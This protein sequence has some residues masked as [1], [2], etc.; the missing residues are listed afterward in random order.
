M[1]VSELLKRYRKEND[2]SLSEFAKRADLSKGYVSMLERGVNPR[3]NKP[4]SPTLV[5]LDKI[6]KA[7]N[8]NFDDLLTLLDSDELL[9]IDENDTINELSTFLS[10]IRIVKN[11]EDDNDAL[12]L[13]AYHRADEITQKHVRLLLGINEE[14]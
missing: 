12:L 9:S 3:N 2:L 6:A 4:I 5:S 7:M 8:I 10:R 1:K 11:N 14:V 13:L